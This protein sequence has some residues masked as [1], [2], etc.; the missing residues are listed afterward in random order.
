MRKIL[1]IF[2]LFVVLSGVGGVIHHFFGWFRAWTL[3]TRQAFLDGHELAAGFV[4]IIF[5]LLVWIL[6]EAL[7]PTEKER[8]K[9]AEKSATRARRSGR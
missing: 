8:N 9:K 1:D 4:L 7:L 3:V 5:G 6:G 2:G